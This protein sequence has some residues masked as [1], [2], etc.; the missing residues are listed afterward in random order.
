MLAVRVLLEKRQR[1]VRSPNEYLVLI[2]RFNLASIIPRSAFSPTGKMILPNY[3]AVARTLLRSQRQ[4]LVSDFP[5][6][7]SAAEPQCTE[8]TLHNRACI[9]K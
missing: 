6:C 9:S 8:H 2:S 3:R 4:A 1:S 7:I 5:E